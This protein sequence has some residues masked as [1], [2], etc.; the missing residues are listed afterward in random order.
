MSRN[1]VQIDDPVVAINI[2]Q[3]YRHGINDDDLYDCTRGIWRLNKDH[4]EKATYAFAVYQGV[5]KEVYEIDKWFPAGSTKYLRRRFNPT[6]LFERFEF[7]G[8]V[9][10]D[11]VRGKYIGKTMPI[12]PGRNPI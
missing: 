9:A 4:A 5:I 11:N 8:R 6:D 7:I 1:E 2:N 10:P 3:T 12:R